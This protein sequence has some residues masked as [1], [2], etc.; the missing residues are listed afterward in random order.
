MHNE[1]LFCR[2]CGY[3]SKIFPWGLDGKTPLYDY[4]L[5]CG[6]EH[7][8]Q[9]GSPIGARNF[10]KLWVESGANWADKSAKP[11][12]WTLDEQLEQVPFEFR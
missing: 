4:C 10:R 6:V 1:K 3:K 5:C 2:V 7:G 8:Y 9:D 12:G 11:E